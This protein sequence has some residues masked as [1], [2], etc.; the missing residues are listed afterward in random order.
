MAMD[1]GGAEWDIPSMAD[2]FGDLLRRFR[3]AAS[4]TQEALADR[5]RI[6]P[7]TIAA[8][9]QGRRIAPRLSTVRLIAS[10][11]ELSA[12][13]RE[14]LARAADSGTSTARPV[15][16]DV[17]ERADH[18]GDGVVNSVSAVTGSSATGTA[19]TMAVTIV[20]PEFIGRREE[21]ASL[22]A[23]MNRTQAGEPGFMLVGGEAGVGKSRL[24]T[25]F[26]VRAASQSGFRVLTGQ[27]VELGAEGLPLAPLVDALRTLR[28]GLT[29]EALTE[30]LGQAGTGLARL[31]PE[32]GLANP[33]G[34]PPEDLQKAQLLEMVLGLLQ[35][36][37]DRQ[38]ILLLIEDLHWA[39]Q[40]TLDLIAFLARSLREAR[41]LLVMTYRSDELHRRHPLRPLLTGWERVRSISRIELLRFERDEVTA[42]LAA[43][44]GVAPAEAVIDVVFDRSGGN[45][46]LV[47]ELAGAV[48]SD[49]DL[50]DLPPSLKD[51]L[52]SR[53]DALSSGA[54]RLLRVAAVAGR[55]VA[56]RLLAEVAGMGEAEF[57]AGLREAVDS[58]L[59]Q[60]D[61]SG[62]GY[63]FRHSLTRDAVYE[64]MLPG[65]RVRL[66]AAYGAA[67]ASDPEV[68]GDKAALPAALAYHWYAALDLPRA[69]TAA[70]E[71][72]Q[73]AT[74][75][76]APAEALRYLE[77]AQE[78]W[79]RVAD[80]ADRTG[81]DQVELG[82]LAAEAAYRSG[83][84]D[85]SQSLLA[86]ALAALPEGTDPVRRALL[87]ERYAH[88]QRDRGQQPA[89]VRSLREALALLPADQSSRAH[90]VVLA[91]LAATQSHGAE[92]A[93]AAEVAGRAI[94]AAQAAGARDVEADATITL[95]SVSSYL[96][97]P[98]TSLYSLRSGIALALDLDIPFTA[99]RGYINLSDVQELLGRHL[100]AVQ[101]AREGLELAERMGMARTLGCYLT[102]NQ[103]E[104]L[105]RLG[106]WAEADPLT[107]RALGWQPEGVF[108]A[109]LRQL[110][111][112]LAAMRGDYDEAMREL[113]ETRRLVGPTTDIQFTQ[114][115]R[116]AE[117]LIGLG[118]GDLQ[119]AR[120]AVTAGFADAELPESARFT[121]PLLWLGMRIEADEATR[122]RDRR[123]AVPPE[124]AQRCDA[125]AQVAARLVKPAAPAHGY[126]ALVAAEHRRAGTDDAEVWAMAVV[127]W[128][129]AD[130]PYPLAYALLRLAEA[131]EEAG[132]REHAAEAILQAHALAARIGAAP[133]AA[134]AAAFAR[135]IRLSLDPASVG[136][137]NAAEPEQPDEL[138]RFGLTDR[139][140]EVLRLLA[141][142]RSNPEIAQALFISAKTVSVHVS[143]ILAKLGVSGRVEAAT[144]A[145]RLGVG[146]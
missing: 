56:D 122:L 111:S 110:R 146:A 39:D 5:C 68:A 4:L 125:L 135:R 50:A 62:L 28:R 116:Y 45:A 92:M 95:G 12:A 105:L 129:Q 30:V 41:V 60:V 65:E 20:S 136:E 46:Y 32:L 7:A 96:G 82:R 2:S 78:I 3:V 61:P 87:L 90:A 91:T 80:A 140:R 124:I 48:R 15:A 114:P 54:Q 64:D 126:Q 53:A 81:I 139:E 85:R 76:Y 84:L 89:A 102:G 106:R 16:A 66:H 115:I 58:H 55:T 133:V 26:A 43:I 75:A 49:G 23:L 51:V 145:H 143:N 132:S 13:D 9:E 123:E 37:S 24:V 1:S 19:S 21:I 70:I 67:L 144:V 120:E 107:A 112:E 77:R 17:G 42:Q 10:A 73:H 94:A 113:R 27:C 100:E 57:F 18:H 35:R 36:L 34:N 109:T 52:L 22:S 69:L 33:H 47:E 131:H 63:A 93:D 29:P 83:A 40:S 141:A 88:A 99:L 97:Q 130:E 121:W 118:R 103:V 25:E 128:Q 119:T 98:E 127:A 142:G 14:L 59:L 108:A 44:L 31:L 72:A 117:A 138:A 11:L 86:D 101:T 134:E 71:A 6:S 137:Q 104:P 79:P 38:P 8:I 74:S